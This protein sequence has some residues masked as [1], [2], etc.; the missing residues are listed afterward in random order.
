[1]L[2]NLFL[3]LCE[4]FRKFSRTPDD[5]SRDIQAMKQKTQLDYLSL[6]SLHLT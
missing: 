2:D 5:F 1:M 3:L 6:L 4:P